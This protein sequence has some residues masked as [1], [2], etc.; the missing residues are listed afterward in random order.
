MYWLKCMTLFQY[1]HTPSKFGV[2]CCEGPS[3]IQQSVII[4]CV[5]SASWHNFQ[6]VMSYFQEITLDDG[7]CLDSKG[8]RDINRTWAA[9]RPQR[10]PKFRKRI[11]S[12][13]LASAIE[14]SQEARPNETTKWMR[15]SYSISLA[16]LHGSD[17]VS[18][19][20]GCIHHNSPCWHLFPVIW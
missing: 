5:T 15:G 9:S 16:L 1:R 11:I 8:K 4:F 13:L 10:C 19:R 6:D 17:Q 2:Q 7:V 3:F 12:F 20:K 14:R 18:W